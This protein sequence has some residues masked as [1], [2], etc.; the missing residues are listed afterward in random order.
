MGHL[1]EV[2]SDTFQGAVTG[3]AVPVLVKFTGAG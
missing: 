3:S 1:P 2:T